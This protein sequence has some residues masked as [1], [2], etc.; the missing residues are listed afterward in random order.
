ME[1][2]GPIIKSWEGYRE[3]IALPSML[4]VKV[5]DIVARRRAREIVMMR[6]RGVEI[7]GGLVHQ[8]PAMTEALANLSRVDA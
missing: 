4:R 5:N 8:T 2:V 7:E 1:A 6:E 3:I